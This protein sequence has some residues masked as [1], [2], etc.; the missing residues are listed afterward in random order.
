[1]TQMDDSEKEQMRRQMLETLNTAREATP[2]EDVNKKSYDEDFEFSRKKL[3]DLIEKS[4]DAIENFIEVAKETEEPSAYRVLNEMLGTAGE[5]V[6]AVT[7][8]SKTK[9]EIDKNLIKKDSQDIKTGNSI[10]TNNIYVGSTKELLQKLNQEESK[11]ID[12]DPS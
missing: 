7:E 9:T 1:M 3:K 8:T 4:Y 6:K 11:I 12:L 5:L 2:V 10:T